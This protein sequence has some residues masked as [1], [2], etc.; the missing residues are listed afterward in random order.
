MHFYILSFLLV[1]FFMYQALKQ[2]PPVTW[3]LM[4]RHFIITVAVAM[5]TSWDVYRV[6]FTLTHPQL[7]MTAFYVGKGFAPAWIVFSLSVTYMIL[8]AIIWGQS[9]SLAARK[10]K[11]RRLF[12]QVWPFY[13]IIFMVQYVTIVQ[14]SGV[15]RSSGY[16]FAYYI[17]GIVIQVFLGFVIYL[18]FRSSSSDAIFFPSKAA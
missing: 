5:L 10:P 8:G 16:F 2:P 12:L 3:R 13:M 15:V 1:S 6:F 9:F 14:E 4:I 17:F 11:A 7:A 18:H